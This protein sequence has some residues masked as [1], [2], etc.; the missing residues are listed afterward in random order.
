MQWK[1]CQVCFDS[2]RDIKRKRR[3]VS[4]LKCGH[5]FCLRCVKSHVKCSITYPDP[6]ET[7]IWGYPRCPIYHCHYH[8]RNKR[9]FTKKVWDLANKQI[10]LKAQLKK[11]IQ[12]CP[13]IDCNGIVQKVGNNQRCDECKAMICQICK[14]AKTTKNHVCLKIEKMSVAQQ[15]LFMKCPTCNTSIQKNGGCDDMFCVICDSHF[16]Y[17]D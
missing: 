2:F 10:K 11:R 5:S 4:K 15:L 9:F 8:I 1:I 13:V 6:D 7:A 12:H 17:V 16:D 3:R 14:D